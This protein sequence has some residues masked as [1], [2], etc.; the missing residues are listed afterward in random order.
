METSVKLCAAALALSLTLLMLGGC[1]HRACPPGY[2]LG[3]YGQ[4]CWI[5]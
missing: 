5:N 3:P 2:H 1:A 4:R